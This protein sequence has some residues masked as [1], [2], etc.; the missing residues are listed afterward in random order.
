MRAPGKRSAQIK[1]FGTL[2]STSSADRNEP[3]SRHLTR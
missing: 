3:A 1:L 2:T